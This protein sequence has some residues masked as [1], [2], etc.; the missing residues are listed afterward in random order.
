MRG[1]DAGMGTLFSYVEVEERIRPGHPLRRIWDIANAA[2]PA[3]DEDFERIY[4]PRLD[5][6]RFHRSGCSE[7]CCCRRSMASV[8]APVDGADRVRPVVPLVRR[9]GRR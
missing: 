4:P 5:G 1:S 7:R 8:R 2:L 3:L 9:L 6:L